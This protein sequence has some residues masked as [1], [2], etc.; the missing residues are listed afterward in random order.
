MAHFSKLL[1][2]FIVAAT[3]AVPFSATALGKPFGGRLVSPPIPCANI[4]G[5]FL[6]SIIPAGIIG[7]FYVYTPV[8]SLGLRP[9]THPGQQ[10]L[11]IADA[12]L[13]CNGILSQRIQIFG[14][15][16]I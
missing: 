9:P 13:V 6:I 15:S 8:L 3:L 5:S 16:I 10:I 12:P 2:V 7:P 1:A 4:P 14:V 11:G